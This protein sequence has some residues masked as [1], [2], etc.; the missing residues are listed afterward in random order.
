[1]LVRGF[2]LFRL[3][4]IKLSDAQ[5]GPSSNQPDV[6]VLR[7]GK[8]NHPKYGEFEVTP[9]VLAEFKS[10]FDKGIRGVDIAFDYFHNSDQEAA[11]WPTE[12]YL[13][14]DGNELWAKV[15]WTS[16]ARKMLAEREVRYFSPDFAFLWKDPETGV[17]YKNVLFGGGLTNRPFV[18][19]MAA[20]VA[21]EE[22]EEQMKI[23][24]LAA[25]V[26][27]LSEDQGGLQAAHDK[28]KGDHAA[29]LQ[30]HGELQ[31]KLEE[32]APTPLAPAAEPKQSDADEND[33]MKLKEKIANMQKQLDEYAEGK[34][35]SEKKAEFNVL[36]SE[37]KACAAQEKA[38]I[39]GDMTQFIKLAQ[40]VNLEGKGSTESGDAGKTE[41]TAADDDK[42]LKLA[43]EKVKADPKLELLAAITL[44]H[45][46]LRV[47][48]K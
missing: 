38:Y 34:K 5:S 31:A 8:F 17:A 33:P 44:A 23:E 19:D 20:I 32:K 24:E 48:K 30:K 12:L 39:A 11:G 15:D 37:G 42:V 14:D 45:Q 35:M 13:S 36:L 46:E 21:A 9:L 47:A 7:V 2:E 18:K 25:Q 41:L 29:L 43:E 16:K 4:A 10:N 40:K 22:K 1:M 28:L 27:K 3:S 6:Q 26:K